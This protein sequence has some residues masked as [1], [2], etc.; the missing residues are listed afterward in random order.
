[1]LARLLL[2]VNVEDALSY[3]GCAGSTRL[4]HL[5]EARL[6]VAAS[7]EVAAMVRDLS[8]LGCLGD[9]VSVEQ[10]MKAQVFAPDFTDLT[11]EETIILQMY[12]WRI[13]MHAIAVHDEDLFFNVEIHD[14]NYKMTRYAVYTQGMMDFESDPRCRHRRCSYQSSSQR[15]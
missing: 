10:A 1:M 5:E 11:D 14:E 15:L 13:R 8:E 9:T 6:L 4:H 3:L 12:L 7:R 2:D